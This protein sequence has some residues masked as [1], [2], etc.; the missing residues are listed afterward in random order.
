MFT[1]QRDEHNHKKQSVLVRDLCDYSKNCIDDS[2]KRSMRSGDLIL[3]AARLQGP[4][5]EN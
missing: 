3:L 4:A 5:F 2:C 1:R